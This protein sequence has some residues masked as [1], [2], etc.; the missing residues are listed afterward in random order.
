MSLT[1]AL[2]YFREHHS[3]CHLKRKIKNKKEVLTVLSLFISCFA[4]V[5]RYHEVCQGREFS[6]P[7]K[8][9]LIL[10]IKDEEEGS[11]SK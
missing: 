4:Q 3:N 6:K 11:K 10:V 8:T 2:C 1:S 5:N 9:L 7:R